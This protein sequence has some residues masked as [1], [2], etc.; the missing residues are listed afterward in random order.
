MKYRVVIGYGYRSLTFEFEES[1]DAVAFATTAIK[2]YVDMDGDDK[3]TVNIHIS[4]G[5]SDD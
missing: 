1:T 4:N 5:E 3:L 2:N